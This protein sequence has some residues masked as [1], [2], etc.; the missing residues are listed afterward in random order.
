MWGA[1]LTNIRNI[2]STGVPNAKGKEFKGIIL[3]DNNQ[4]M[5]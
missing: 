5:L 2:A 3:G 4:S 1:R